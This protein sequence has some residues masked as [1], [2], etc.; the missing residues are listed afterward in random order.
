M[1]EE[2]YLFLPGLLNRD[3]VLE[4]RRPSSSGSWPK[5]T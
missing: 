5:G 1:A 4:A 3:E 2:G